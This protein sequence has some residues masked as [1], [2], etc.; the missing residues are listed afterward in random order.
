MYQSLIG[1]LQWVIFLGRWDIACAVMTMS[2]FRVAPRRGHLE[3]LKRICGYP[4]KMKHFGIRF[5]THEPDFSD[6]EETIQDWFSVY[7]EVQEELPTDAPQPLGKPVQLIHYVDANLLHDK[8][9]G[10]SITACLHF[11][12]ATPIDWYSKKQGTV[13]TATYSSEFV[14]A[15]TC[16]EQLIDLRN[17]LRYL[18]VQVN[19]KSYMFGDNESVVNSSTVL[20]AKLH[21]RHN[22]LS[23]HRVREA[24]ASRYVD[25]NY[26]P[27]PQNPADVLS[28]HWGYSA[29][30]DVLL[31]LFHRYGETVSDK[32]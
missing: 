1:A 10:K 24:I 26:L 12:N 4:L 14:A 17:T 11:V 28:K 6:L 21:K 3:R 25:F 2:S 31:P 20:Y 30:K 19:E 16:V 22:L 8:L 9:S 5:R 27:G 29:V 15:R 32:G 7:G 18:G 23:F 13:E